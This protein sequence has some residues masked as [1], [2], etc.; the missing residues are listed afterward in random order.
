MK[1]SDKTT[2]HI[3]IKASTNSEWDCC[4]F[5]LIH[6]SEEWKKLQATRFEA[7]KPFTDDYTFQSIRFYSTSVAFY[8]SGDDGTPDIEELLADK[9]WAFVEIDKDELDE[10]TPP[11]N[12]LDFY[13][14]EI[15]RDGNARYKAY[16][17][18]TNEEFWT[19]EF[20]LQQLTEQTIEFRK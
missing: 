15:H 13:V 18:H 2:E 19:N 20:S 7:V 17:K 5:A 14:L 16:G 6:L 3:L 12:S 9:D 8:Q 4:E 11:E 10:L 1:I